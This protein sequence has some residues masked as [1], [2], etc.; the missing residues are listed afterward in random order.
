MF[1]DKSII[2]NSLLE[3]LWKNGISYIENVYDIYGAI[4]YITTYKKPTIM[5]FN[6]NYTNFPRNAKIIS[7]SQHFG[8]ETPKEKII[9]EKISKEQLNELRRNKNNHD[10]ITFY[11]YF[12]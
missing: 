12:L 5:Q 6:S 8:A 3:K 4:E 10:F 2:P 11:I 7:T 9:K 1:S